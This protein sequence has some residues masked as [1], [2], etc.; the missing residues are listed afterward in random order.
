MSG[1]SGE[2]QLFLGENQNNVF[3]AILN[4]SAFE[5]KSELL[6]EFLVRKV[7]LLP[8]LLVVCILMPPWGFG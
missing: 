4:S 3:R 8:D 6:N 2:V 5:I 1:V 7:V